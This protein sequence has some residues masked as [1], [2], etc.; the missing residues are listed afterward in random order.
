MTNFFAGCDPGK[1]IY[2]N[3]SKCIDKYALISCCQ[4]GYM[5]PKVTAQVTLPHSYHH[6]KLQIFEAILFQIFE[7]NCSDS[8]KIARFV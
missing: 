7:V 2:T 5:Q 8:L 6:T 4:S 3:L 1:R